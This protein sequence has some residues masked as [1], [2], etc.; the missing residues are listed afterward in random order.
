MIY[1]IFVLRTLRL[2][3]FDKKSLSTQ[4]SK[5]LS[6]LIFVLLLYLVL[7]GTRRIDSFCF[8]TGDNHYINHQILYPF[9]TDIW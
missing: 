3:D 9:L 2:M 5:L 1:I 7:R 6:S 4:K 8:E